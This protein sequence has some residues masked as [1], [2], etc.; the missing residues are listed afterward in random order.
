MV[1]N[2]KVLEFIVLNNSVM[3][4]IPRGV[5]DFAFHP[6]SPQQC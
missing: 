4:V 5:V 1:K 3:S 2:E 6:Y